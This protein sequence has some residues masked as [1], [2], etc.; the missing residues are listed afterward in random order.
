MVSKQ[1]IQSRPGA[2]FVKLSDSTNLQVSTV[3]FYFEGADI[4]LD[5]I[6]L[7]NIENPKVHL[8]S[9]WIDECRVDSSKEESKP[10]E[11]EIIVS[12]DSF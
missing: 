2:L 1:R 11:N 9:Q 5:S 6:E 7:G 10:K 12:T 8:L 4:F 3:S